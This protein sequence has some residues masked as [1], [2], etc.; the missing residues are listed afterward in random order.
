MILYHNFFKQQ[1]LFIVPSVPVLMCWLEIYPEDFYEQKQQKQTT[2]KSNA[3]GGGGGTIG[4]HNANGNAT[5]KLYADGRR[6]RC[7]RPSSVIAGT[8]LRF[9][10]L[11][12]LVDFARTH[13]LHDLKQ[14]GK[15]ERLRRAPRTAD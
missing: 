11:D 13:A 5:N 7:R 1:Q 6:R 9:P 4:Q 12:A 15:R 14:K 2:L 3:S 8:L 10:T